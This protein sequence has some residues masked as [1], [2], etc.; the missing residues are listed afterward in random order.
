LILVVVLYRVLALEYRSVQDLISTYRTATTTKRAELASLAT[1]PSVFQS[2]RCASCGGSLELP[3]VH[4]LCK[5]LSTNAVSIF[6]LP[7]QQIGRSWRIHWSVLFC[8]KEYA[9]IKA[10]RRAQEDATGRHNLSLDVLRRSKDRLGTV[11]EFFG[12]GVWGNGRNESRR[13]L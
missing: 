1:K 11:A 4:F 3:T 5:I 9:T 6:P 2:L 7:G 12:R 8:A 10:I 13:F